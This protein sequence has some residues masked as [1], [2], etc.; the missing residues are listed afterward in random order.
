M[1][2]DNGT[3][4]LT[5]AGRSSTVAVQGTSVATHL[6]SGG[7]IDKYVY[8]APEMWP[9]DGK[10]DEIRITKENDVYGMGMVAYEVNFT[11][12]RNPAQGSNLTSAS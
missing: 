2:D 6:Q 1:I 5:F 7:E 8:A 12:P 10:E 9:E 3:A 11:V 4:R